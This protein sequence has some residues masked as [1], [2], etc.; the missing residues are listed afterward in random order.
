MG[1][2]NIK[3]HI[4]TAEKTGACQLCKLGLKEF[5][6][7]IKKLSK[8]LRTLDL[9]EN[10]IPSIPP[11]IGGFSL[12]KTLSMNNNR[13]G[14]LPEEIGNLKKLETLSLENNMLTSLPVSFKNLSHLRTLSLAGNGFR[15]FPDVLSD[16][17]SLDAVDLSRNKMSEIPG[18]VRI[19]QVI[20]L[21]LN[22]NQISTLPESI[23][24]WPR[25]KVLRLEEN[26]LEI[27]ALTPKIMKESKIALFAV[28][29]NVFD[30]KM[31]THIDGY[32]QYMER[33]TATK[34]KFN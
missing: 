12:M 25:L 34:K 29:G 19:C 23:A 13:I 9:S 14:S 1:N 4:E 27:T 30:M 24:E 16:L 5:P 6:E 22:Q 33:Y 8:N 18:N 32:D 11:Y 26:C 2:S 20:E 10:K 28:E 15:S 3:Q 31:F 17:K 21:N 7:D